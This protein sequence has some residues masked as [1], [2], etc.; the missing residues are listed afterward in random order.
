M[1]MGIDRRERVTS[2]VAL[3]KSREQSRNVY[4]NKE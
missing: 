3:I 1:A 4:E 2:K